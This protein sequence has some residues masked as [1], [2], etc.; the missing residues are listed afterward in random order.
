MRKLL[1]SAFVLI[2]CAPTG[3]ATAQNGE[4]T[5]SAQPA[6]GETIVL[7]SQV[8]QRASKQGA[9]CDELVLD[10]DT[11]HVALLTVTWQHPG[12]SETSEAVVPWCSSIPNNQL[13]SDFWKKLSRAPA[14]GFNRDFVSKV[15]SSAKE[16]IY[17]SDKL[18]DAKSADKFDAKNYKLSTFSQ[19]VGQGVKDKSGEPL[20][21]IVDLGINDTTGEIIYCVLESSDSKFRA[22]PLAAFVAS[23]KSKAWTIALDR[24]QV[25]A[26]ETCDLKNPPQSLAR[27]WQEYVAVKYGRNGLGQ[28]EAQKE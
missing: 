22:I 9:Q 28:A 17:W 16:E 11:A 21:K 1:F 8:L 12:Q 27:G 6:A 15:Y 25:F 13:D 7:A 10:L 19:L 4:A 3:N 23:K 5:K 2:A 24:E 18:A 26:F 20:G 14:E